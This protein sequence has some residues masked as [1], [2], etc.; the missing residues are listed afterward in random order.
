[1]GNKRWM[2]MNKQELRTLAKTI[3]SSIVEEQRVRDAKTLKDNIIQHFDGHG[4]PDLLGVYYPANNE[5]RPPHDIPNV[6]MA[7]PVVRDK[8]TLEFYQWSIDAPV[9]VRDYN[10]P[11][12]DTRGLSPVI[13][14]HI[15]VPLVMCDVHG[16]RIGNGAGHY[17]RYLAS[18][19]TKPKLIGVCFDEQ[20]FDGE[21]PFE[22]HD[23]KLDLIITPTRII[24]IP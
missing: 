1:M 3:R 5:I 24:T 21:L 9:I 12:P 4:Y 17:D 13:S 14:T 6:E 10:I 19:P 16:N 18:L 22:P 23:I 15:L 20:I 2:A 7:L 8:T 11:I